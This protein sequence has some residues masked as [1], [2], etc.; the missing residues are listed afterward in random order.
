M[1][2]MDI[3][4]TQEIVFKSI[5]SGDNS[6]LLPFFCEFAVKTSDLGKYAPWFESSYPE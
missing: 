6:D 3:L 2:L 5:L 1:K 4:N